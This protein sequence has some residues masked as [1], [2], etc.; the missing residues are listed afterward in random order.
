[1]KNEVLS[2]IIE[3]SEEA[4]TNDRYFEQLPKYMFRLILKGIIDYISYHSTIIL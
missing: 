3:R 2:E 1:M 4:T